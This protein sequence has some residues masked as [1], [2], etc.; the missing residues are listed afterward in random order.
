MT[1]GVREINKNNNR[2]F[3]KKIEYHGEKFDSMR[4]ANFFKKFVEPFDYNYTLHESFRL[5]PV[6]ELCNGA[7]KLR[8]SSYRPDVVIR[9]DE[10]NL[11]HVIDIKSGFNTQYNIDPAAALRFKL[12]AMR[13]GV[14][15]EVV[16]PNLKSFRVKIMGTTKKFETATKYDLN[17]TID[18][19]VNERQG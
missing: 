12:F 2:Y 9:D 11:L 15:V 3:G 14:P 13:Y 19:L 8:S 7:L 4:E 16:V 6:I 5:H 18:D 1:L 10:G 17:Y